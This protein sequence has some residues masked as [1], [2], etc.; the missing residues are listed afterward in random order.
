MGKKKVA[1]HKTVRKL[2]EVVQYPEH[3]ERTES[4]LFRETK[5]RLRKDG[6]YKCY[7][8]GT[9]KVLQVHHYGGEWALSETI[10]LS[11]LKEFLEEWDVYGYGKLM[12]NVPLTSVDDVRNAMVLCQEH[13][14][15]GTSDGSANG[16]HNITFPAWISQKLAMKGTETVPLEDDSLA[17]V[18]E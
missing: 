4:K 18:E 7:I 16:I 6:H 5:K 13:H 2:V 1:A 8:C 10:D 9:T 17:K 3:E 12:K 14:T 11:V 15:G